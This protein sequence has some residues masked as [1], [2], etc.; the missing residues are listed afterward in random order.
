M[1]KILPV[2]AILMDFGTFFGF[3]TCIFKY[4]SIYFILRHR[5]G[6]Y[7]QFYLQSKM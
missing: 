1:Y 2:F 7:F 3:I 4:E 5:K 6:Y